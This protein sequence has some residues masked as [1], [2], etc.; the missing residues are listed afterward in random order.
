MACFST[1][2]LLAKVCMILHSLLKIWLLRAGVKLHFTKYG[3]VKKKALW[4]HSAKQE[5]VK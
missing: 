4:N 2:I 3:C 1:Y 5:G